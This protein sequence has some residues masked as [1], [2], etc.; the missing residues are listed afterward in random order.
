MVLKGQSLL[1]TC[2][3]QH[4]ISTRAS[5]TVVDATS[6]DILPIS[7]PR[8]SLSVPDLLC[9]SNKPQNNSPRSLTRSSRS[10]SAIHVP[11]SF[12]ADETLVESRP[13]RSHFWR[14][15]K[16]CRLG[17]KDN[18][19]DSLS[20]ENICTNSHRP[21]DFRSVFSSLQQQDCRH[22]PCDRSPDGKVPVGEPAKESDAIGCERIPSAVQR[23]RAKIDSNL[24]EDETHK[25]AQSDGFHSDMNGLPLIQCTSQGSS[26]ASF[27][28]QNMQITQRLR[29]SSNTS[30]NISIVT[31]RTNKKS[32]RS[33]TPSNLAYATGVQTDNLHHRHVSSSGFVSAKVPISWGRI[34]RGESPSLYSSRPDSNTASPRTSTMYLPYSISSETRT[35]TAIS[36]SF[37]TAESQVDGPGQPS[38]NDQVYSKKPV[39]DSTLLPPVI[40]EGADSP[41]AKQTQRSQASS[42][43]LS[44]TSKFVEDIDALSDEPTQAFP[45][46]PKKK[47]S[48]LNFFRFPR[49]NTKPFR[50]RISTYDGPADAPDQTPRAS[51]PLLSSHDDAA[52]M[53]ER[54]L[55]VHAQEKATMWLKPEDHRGDLTS[56]RERRHS[57]ARSR[58]SSNAR[59]SHQ[60]S[61]FL[62]PAQDSVDVDPFDIRRN[63]GSS[64]DCLGRPSGVHL[65]Q[66]QKRA[67]SYAGRSAGESPE[68]GS[69]ELS[70]WSRY[71]SHT[72]PQRCGSAGPDDNVFPRDFGVMPFDEL[73][74]APS[75]I[76]PDARVPGNPDAKR[77]RKRFSFG[78]RSGKSGNNVKRAKGRLPKS[79]SLNFGRTV[80]KHYA[81]FFKPQSHEFFHY[82][83][84]HRS[85]ISTGGTLENPDLEILRPVISPFPGN[86]PKMNSQVAPGIELANLDSRNARKFK[87]KAKVVDGACETTSE[88]GHVP[89]DKSIP[90]P[91]TNNKLDGLTSDLGRRSS[92]DNYSGI[93]RECFSDL[94]DSI[95]THRSTGRLS[96]E[97]E[98]RLPY[99]RSESVVDQ[100]EGAKVASLASTWSKVYDDCVD[101]TFLRCHPSSYNDVVQDEQVNFCSNRVQNPG[102][103]VH[104]DNGSNSCP[105]IHSRRSSSCSTRPGTVINSG[106]SSPRRAKNLKRI[107][108]AALKQD[109]LLPLSKYQ[110]L[111]SQGGLVASLQDA[112]QALASSVSA[113]LLGKSEASFVE[114][115][116][117]NEGVERASVLR[118]AEE[119]IN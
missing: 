63:R 42:S 80:L 14:L 34:T 5:Q 119:L 12:V 40:S 106:T 32:R 81:S 45:P 59:S 46:S 86:A 52:E 2:L 74:E 35:P 10:E 92:N 75:N 103:E 24:Q 21:K 13:A 4:T 72:R 16:D 68:E 50:A 102:H 104:V 94:V 56:K 7:S 98:R 43:N 107:P 117:R 73:H 111:R 101:H 71:P 97:R 38:D 25:A 99:S 61:T 113:P 18:H 36:P 29:S 112:G 67:V 88:C 82:G 78:S 51:I 11:K 3:S 91:A 22:S 23:F 114:A 115:L 96:R 27:H 64:L 31:R 85:S 62:T 95:D 47:R 44:R 65:S 60:A 49:A 30:D 84:G 17:Q 109:R 77:F 87:G 118:R 1:I 116:K 20:Y 70:A 76:G 55:K 54:A 8:L 89:M 37:A 69:M 6:C 48:T 66:E 93:D 53:W 26:G 57:E 105:T 28:L 41:T 83:H 110:G 39:A 79:R 100:K 108:L 9:A 33:H 19:K 90:T 15:S 58:T